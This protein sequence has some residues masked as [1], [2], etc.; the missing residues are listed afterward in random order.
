[1]EKHGTAGQ[2]TDNNIIRRMRFA[3]WITETTLHTLRTCNIYCFSMATIA[4]RMR[5]NVLLVRMFCC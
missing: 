3:C 4:T 2:A 1:M 5:L